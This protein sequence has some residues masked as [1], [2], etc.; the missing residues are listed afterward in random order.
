[1]THDDNEQDTV[2]NRSGWNYD[3]ARE[4]LANAVTE[5]Q[6]AIEHLQDWRRRGSPVLLDEHIREIKQKLDALREQSGKASA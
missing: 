1:M 2:L 5:M 3:A 4:H 6:S